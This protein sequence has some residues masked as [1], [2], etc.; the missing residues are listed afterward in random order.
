[1]DWGLA[2]VEQVVVAPGAGSFGLGV[3]GFMMK[4]GAMGFIV[5]VEDIAFQCECK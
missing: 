4:G 5:D 2:Q 1:M 3:K